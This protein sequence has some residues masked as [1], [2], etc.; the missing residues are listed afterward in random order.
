MISWNPGRFVSSK[1]G[2]DKGQVYIII[3]ETEEY[4]YLSDGSVRTLGKLKKKKKKH[5]QPIGHGDALMEEKLGRGEPVRDEEVK[6]A[7]KDYLS[8][9][10]QSFI[11]ADAGK[12]EEEN[13]KSRR[14]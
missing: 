1:A 10:H 7:I 6:K 12:W 14:D 11:T 5:V 9:V 3:R 2:H 4:I 8:K 13:V